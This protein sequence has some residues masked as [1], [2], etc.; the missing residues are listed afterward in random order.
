MNSEHNNGGLVNRPPYKL[1]DNNGPHGNIVGQIE[2]DENKF[3]S[4]KSLYVLAGLQMLFGVVLCA[5]QVRKF[6]LN[7]CFSI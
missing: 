3:W 7:F 5:T 4:A 2:Q 1:L 6:C